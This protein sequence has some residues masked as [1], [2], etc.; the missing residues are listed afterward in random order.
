MANKKSI[1]ITYDG[2]VTKKF[3]VTGWVILRP[4]DI[5]RHLEN[6]GIEYASREEAIKNFDPKRP[7]QTVYAVF[8]DPKDDVEGPWL[9]DADLTGPIRNR[10]GFWQLCPW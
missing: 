5:H 8:E 4:E 10:K 1:T 9:A 6:E 2:G 7:T 3:K